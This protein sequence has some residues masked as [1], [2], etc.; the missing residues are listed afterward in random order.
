MRRN[1]C[2]SLTR[3]F[4][5]SLLQVL[6]FRQDER[7]WSLD[8]WLL[9]EVSDRYESF[10]QVHRNEVRRTEFTLDREGL[11]DKLGDLASEAGHRN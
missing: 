3:F 9:S 5:F 6:T 7:L 11:P 10:A 4:A 2:I 1:L 8:Q